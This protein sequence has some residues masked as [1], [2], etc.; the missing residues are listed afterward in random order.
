MGSFPLSLVPSSFLGLEARCAWAPEPVFDLQESAR[1]LGVTKRTLVETVRKRFPEVKLS[2]KVLVSLTSTFGSSLTDYGEVRLVLDTPDGPQEHACLTHYGLFRHAVY[3]RTPHARRYVL[4][5]LDFIHALRTG[6]LRPPVKI[7]VRYRY[8]LD[9]PHGQ[10]SARVREV[11]SELNKSKNTIWRHI[12]RIARGHVT[13]DGLP[14]MQRPGPPKGYGSKVSGWMAECIL[15]EW[16]KTGV[17]KSCYRALLGE[18]ARQGDP[19]PP[20]SYT[21]VQRFLWRNG[22][23]KT[24]IRRRNAKK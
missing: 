20:P 10:R 11:C 16:R 17:K 22:V 19:S 7:A 15:A 1:I 2:P 8:I 6:E 24:D 18:L 13:R 4:R 23:P 9:A 21:A 14:M 3:I 12:N 5:Y